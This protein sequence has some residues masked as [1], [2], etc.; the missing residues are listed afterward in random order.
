[1][2]LGLTTPESRQT[3]E[4]YAVDQHEQD[5]HVGVIVMEVLRML[6]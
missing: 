3:H 5:G 1:M 4:R 2:M 6:C